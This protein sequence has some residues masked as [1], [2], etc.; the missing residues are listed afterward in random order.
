MNRFLLLWEGVSRDCNER[1]ST[2]LRANTDATALLELTASSQA[3]DEEAIDQESHGA[4]DGDRSGGAGEIHSGGIGRPVVSFLRV[5]PVLENDN[6]A[7]GEQ[8]SAD[9]VQDSGNLPRNASREN[10]N[11]N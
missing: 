2:V 1:D 10:F 11:Y 5:A 3:N 8:E 4:N 6:R 7:R 9:E